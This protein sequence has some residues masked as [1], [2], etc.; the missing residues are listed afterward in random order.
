MEMEQLFDFVNRFEFEKI[1]KQFVFVMFGR[2]FV[3][4]KEEM[5]SE[6]LKFERRFVMELANEL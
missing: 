1:E 3:K 6:I 5:L 2:D 4:E